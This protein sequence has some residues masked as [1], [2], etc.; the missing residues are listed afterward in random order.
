MGDELLR[1]YNARENL[2]IS[3]DEEMDDVKRLWSISEAINEKLENAVA[4]VQYAAESGAAKETA[5]VIEAP[6]VET[7][8]VEVSTPDQESV[9]EE[10]VPPPPE[11]DVEQPVE[12]ASKVE[13]EEENLEVNINEGLRDM[14]LTGKGLTREKFDARV[15][16]MN[17]A[18]AEAENLTD[19]DKEDWANF[20]PRMIR[21]IEK[22]GG[23]D[24]NEEPKSIG[25][26]GGE[27]D[28]P[29]PDA[30]VDTAVDTSD[31]EGVPPPP[32]SSVDTA[33]DSGNDEDVP[34]PPDTSVDTAV[35][36]GNDEDVPLPPDTS[37]DTAVD[38]R[39]GSVEK[40]KIDGPRLLED[41]KA[42]LK[43]AI[44]RSKE[45]VKQLP[46]ASPEDKINIR[47]ELDSLEEE[48]ARLKQ[49]MIDSKNER[50][51]DWY[52]KELQRLGELG[53]A[54]KDKKEKEAIVDRINQ[55]QKEMAAVGL[56]IGG[57]AAAEMRR[58]ADQEA[59]AARVETE[60]TTEAERVEA[61]ANAEAERQEQERVA[62]EA[63]ET[64]KAKNIV[65]AKAKAKQ[66]KKERVK[67]TA[68]AAAIGPLGVAGQFV[69]GL[70]PIMGSLPTLP[71]MAVG[72]WSFLKQMIGQE[73]LK[74][75][76]PSESTKKLDEWL[77]KKDKDSAA[78][79]KK[80]GALKRDKEKAKE[81]LN[82]RQKFAERI[83]A[84]SDTSKQTEFSNRA[85]K[86][87]SDEADKVEE[88][89]GLEKDLEDESL[90]VPERQAL[91]AKL[92]AVERAIKEIEKRKQKLEEDLAAAEKEQEESTAQAA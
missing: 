23:F 30:S 16:E 29:P 22:Y 79:K 13:D 33:V 82:E 43:N 56:A 59:E 40:R 38:T 80:T 9:D 39:T 36:S 68:A 6:V 86:I 4:Q 14:G 61:E 66:D 12:P 70:K 60:A 25:S 83:E 72:A 51:H 88:R 64:Q 28:V 32:G 62:E 75:G 31:E 57:I 77:K 58:E 52:V 76:E 84:I 69:F 46:D 55:V 90:T 34:L 18:F 17:K 2:M 63:K 53:G 37:V 42:D 35:D 11:D 67:W 26:E 44:S 45:L 41:V 21:T 20:V 73:E 65:E 81:S 54:S 71:R 85:E 8:V 1:L 92:E 5:P 15:A 50:K 24:P 89:K 27:E 78:E 47:K 10:D 74:F 91:E 7:P 19:Q 87:Y 3:Y 48:K 49:E